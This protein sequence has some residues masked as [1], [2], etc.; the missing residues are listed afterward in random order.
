MRVEER[1][2]EVAG[3]EWER[4]GKGPEAVS[5]HAGDAVG[6]LEA[7]FHDEKR[8]AQDRAAIAL[9]RRWVDDDVRDARLVFQ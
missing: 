8:A 5:L 4:V 1:L 6:A 7:A 3:G 2:A 9:E